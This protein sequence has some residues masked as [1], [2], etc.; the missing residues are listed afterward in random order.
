MCLGARLRA[1][2]A[3]ACAQPAPACGTQEPREPL[4]GEGLCSGAGGDGCRSL[5]GADPA[6]PRLGAPSQEMDCSF[7][8]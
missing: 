1:V 4:L 7:L 2:V 5:P 6:C 3:L 8:G